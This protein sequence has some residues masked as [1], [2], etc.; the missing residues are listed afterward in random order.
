MTKS[1]LLA[2]IDRYCVK[3]DITNEYNTVAPNID[4]Y[5]ID[6]GINHLDFLVRITDNYTTV[7]PGNS[8]TGKGFKRIPLIKLVRAELLEELLK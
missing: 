6:Y 4:Y 2:L 1:E 5:L 8:Y 3:H 7:I